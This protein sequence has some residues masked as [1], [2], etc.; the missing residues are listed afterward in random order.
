M[1]LVRYPSQRL[2]KALI[3]FSISSSAVVIIIFALSPEKMPLSCSIALISLSICCPFRPGIIR[4]MMTR[5]GCS[6]LA[7]NMPSRPLTAVITT[8]PSFPRMDCNINL[9][10]ESRMMGILSLRVWSVIFFHAGD[11]L[12]HCLIRIA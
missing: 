1:G 9:D 7:S 11:A 6:C 8:N 2:E 5:S 10:V 4:S 12:S 3:L